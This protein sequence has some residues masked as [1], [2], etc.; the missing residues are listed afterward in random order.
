MQFKFSASSFVCC[1][2]AIIPN[3][4]H[5]VCFCFCCYGEALEVVE[6]EQIER[7]LALSCRDTLTVAEAEYEMR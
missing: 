2:G 6:K 1:P 7:I 3:P 4:L 5:S